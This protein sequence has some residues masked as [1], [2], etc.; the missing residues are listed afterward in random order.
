[1]KQA[2]L[3]LIVV[4]GAALFPSRAC[5]QDA[6]QGAV[7]ELERR[8]DKQEMALERK[9][10]IGGIVFLYAVFCALWAQNTGRNPWLWFVMG[11]LFN[12]I[13]VVVLLV[14]N[15]EDRKRGRLQELGRINA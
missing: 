7:R 1:V 11:L 4:L 12:V 9:A 8:V 13:S 15:A 5:A 10:G 2:G 14:K 6:A 3:L